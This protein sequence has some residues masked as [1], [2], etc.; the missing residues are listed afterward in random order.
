MIEHTQTINITYIYY[1]FPGVLISLTS[2]IAIM[3]IH[4]TRIA[5]IK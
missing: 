4:A 5:I 1:I 3:T 2:V